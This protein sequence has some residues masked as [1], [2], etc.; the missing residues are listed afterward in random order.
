MLNGIDIYDGQYGINIDQTGASFVILKATQGDW[1][2]T[3]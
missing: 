1:E 3:H 2:Q